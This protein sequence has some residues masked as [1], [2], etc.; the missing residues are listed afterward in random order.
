MHVTRFLCIAMLASHAAFA[1]TKSECLAAS[2]KAQQL[3]DDRKLLDARV[4]FLAC[5]RDECPPAVKK[6]CT[7][8]IAEL[9][10]KTPSVVFRAKDKGQD[11]VAVRVTS[12]GRAITEQLDGRTIPLD[13]GVYTFHFE[14]P[15]NEPVDKQVVLAEGQQNREIVAE[16]GHAEAMKTTIAVQPAAPPKRGAPVGAFVLG[17]VGLVSMA[18]APVFY[19]MG[20]SQKS[21]DET[22][23]NGCKFTGGCSDSEINSIQSKLIVGDVLMFGGAAL[24][25]VGIIWTIVHYASGNKE[26]T[27]TAFDVS[28]TLFGRGAVAS[29][30]IRW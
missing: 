4:Q 7:E 29:T 15:G 21:T 27:T 18:V 9:D 2:E 22:A 28:P 11:V 8:H 30:T 5:A 19:A 26:A 6:D 16:F 10:Q 13:P 12:N 24:L 1:D 14:S 20:L 25:A 3:R 17:G 23:P